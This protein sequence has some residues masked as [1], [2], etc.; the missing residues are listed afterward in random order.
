M[1]VVVYRIRLDNN[2]CIE[3]ETYEVVTEL[4]IGIKD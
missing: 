1:P 3:D 4:K 2:V